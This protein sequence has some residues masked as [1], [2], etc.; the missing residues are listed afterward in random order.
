M[1]L[2]TKDLFET[3]SLLVSSLIRVRLRISDPTNS[4]LDG[5]RLTKIH[6]CSYLFVYSREA[7]L[8]AEEVKKEVLG[9][10]SDVVQVS[11]KL[12]LSPATHTTS[13]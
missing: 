9:T 8:M 3:T 13:A 5:S 10:V 4:I 7:M 11:V 1:I 12:Q 2:S 6:L